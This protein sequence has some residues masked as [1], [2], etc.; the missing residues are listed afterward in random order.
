MDRCQHLTTKGTQCLKPSST[1]IEDDLLFCWQHQECQKQKSEKDT[2]VIK[3]KQVSCSLPRKPK[4]FDQSILSCLD[5]AQSDYLERNKSMNPLNQSEQCLLLNNKKLKY[6]K[7][8][9]DPSSLRQKMTDS[10]LFP[11]MDQ[12]FDFTVR[13][14]CCNCIAI[15]LYWTK[16][17][18]LDK[19]AVYL[20]SI[21][22]TVA[23]V[24]KNL[25]DWII[26]LYLD[27]SVHQSLIAYESN[28]K[29]DTTSLFVTQ[30]LN[31]LLEADNVEIY[32]YCC[33]SIMNKQIPIARTRTF[34]FLPLSDLD[35]NVRIIREADGIVT[36]V[37]CH[38]IKVFSQSDYLF[39]LPDILETT[40]H[41]EEDSLQEERAYS[42]WL[43]N[44]EQCFEKP[45]FEKH[46]PLYDLL[47]GTIGMRLMTKQTYYYQHVN[48]VQQISNLTKKHSCQLSA[49]DKKIL[50]IGFDE[51][52]L[53]DL[54]RDYISAPVKLVVDEDEV[55]AYQFVDS[56]INESILSLISGPHNMQQVTVDLDDN[57]WIESLEQTQL[58]K[59]V[60]VAPSIEFLDK[61]YHE[62]KEIF[63]DDVGDN[64]DEVLAHTYLVD[65]LF[66]ESNMATK[67][68][69]N[70]TVSLH[71]YSDTTTTYV[72]SLFEFIN[73]AYGSRISNVSDL[74]LY[75]LPVY[76]C[77][78][79]Y[80]TY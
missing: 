35:V 71:S 13:K 2:V 29:P 40:D 79:D 57:D 55:E 16:K 17:T 5:S 38:N 31:Y 47:A 11:E 53:L 77:I 54:Y 4:Q 43:N 41:T 72:L 36:N 27:S 28:N 52:L 19:C 67:D 76:D 59:T 48:N 21:K 50:N 20:A 8:T 15:S 51:M 56:D 49:E 69:V 74:D 75:M 60:D 33:Q 10:K 58:L 45:Y 3:G 7:H 80:N 64:F 26:R 25:P 6:Y 32:L 30:T 23:N 14:N 70:V 1:K 44:Y 24:K 62:L 18:E 46:Q 73:Y 78:Y 34:R 39:Y 22:R 37:D 12:A 63:N 66:T 42:S 68:I 9:Y 65:S 61:I